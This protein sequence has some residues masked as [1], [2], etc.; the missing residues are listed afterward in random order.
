MN[1]I[2]RAW[3]VVG[4]SLAFAATPAAHAVAPAAIAAAALCT[5][6]SARGVTCGV[7]IDQLH[8]TQ[9]T[10]GA[11]EVE[12]RAAKIAD[13]D[14][15]ERRS[16]LKEH[17]VPL[18]VGPQ[19]VFYV[20]DHHHFAMAYA[21]IV[22][23]SAVVLAT[24]QENWGTLD[25]AVFW[26]KMADAQYTY[27]FDEHGEGPMTLAALP[28]DVFGLRDDPFRSLAWG[29]KKAGGYQDST[30]PHADF[31]WANFL[32]TRFAADTVRGDFDTTVER[33]VDAAHSASARD[34]PGYQ[35]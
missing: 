35:P 6:Q 10:Y 1:W 32:R 18:V 9:L 28:Q 30:V 2:S 15:A 4:I 34:L 7:A 11:I 26:P 23:D 8:P 21:Q 24:I 3:R 12:R 27:L 20:T 16:Y 29:V 14:A 19:G 25:P 22:G 13:M 31:Q 33:A 5:A 17:V